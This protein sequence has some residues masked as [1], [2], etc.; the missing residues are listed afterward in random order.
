MA[1]TCPWMD[2]HIFPQAPLFLRLFLLL[3]LVLRLM[4]QLDW[5]HLRGGPSQSD[6][7]D[8]LIPANQAKTHISPLKSNVREFRDFPGRSGGFT[9]EP[10]FRGNSSLLQLASSSTSSAQNHWSDEVI[11][12]FT[13]V[14]DKVVPDGFLSDFCTSVAVDLVSCT[15]PGISP[16]GWKVPRSR[17]HRVRS[18]L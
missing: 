12:C 3:C 1:L 9:V 4:S 14:A 6:P 16:E 5:L 15:P 13:L 7:R 17:I 2:G 8:P 11:L 10:E 18:F